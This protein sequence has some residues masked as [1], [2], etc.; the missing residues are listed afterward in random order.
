M[1]YL[2]I[3]NSA[4]GNAAAAAI[5]RFDLTGELVILGAESYPSYYRPLIPHLVDGTKHGDDLLREPSHMPPAVTVRLNCRVT[6]ID[7]AAGTVTLAG[8]EELGFD[9]LLLA[10]GS[11][12]IKPAIPGLG[13]PGVFTL[14]TWDDALA[15]RRAAGEGQRVVI[16]GGGRVGTKSAFA[17]RSLGLEVTV[18]ELM[19]RIV[20]Q[21]LD[22]VAA[23]IFAARIEQAGIRLRL[24]QTIREVI[25]EKGKLTGVV[26]NE[27]TRLPADIVLVCTGVRANVELAQAAG[28]VVGQGVHV[29]E[30]M[31]TSAPEVYAAGDVVET[32]D[33]VTGRTI[34][35]GI[36]TNAVGMG[37]CA[38]ENMAGGQRHFAAAFSLL[39]AMELGGLPV[40]SVGLIHPPE[41]EG[42]EVHAVRR[43]DTY[44][45]LVLQEGRLVGLILINEI[46]RAGVYQTL[47]RE[48]ADTTLF[49][50][51]LLS[52]RFHYGHFVSYQP[53]EVDRFL[54]V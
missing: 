41:G 14:R 38:G 43:G 31:R 18:V 23:S 49:R 13:Q 42:Y 21:Q 45:K 24:G 52:A 54:T 26:L 37:A 30:G 32:T 51:K 2:I 7:P 28:L 53:R 20:P 9:R 8:E 25:H 50:D 15:I 3:G 33:V 17:L 36:W 44:R 39:N 46:E 22:E 40:V 6:S 11:T 48:R 16:L 1:R 34:V 35:S 10:T 12:S 27:G 19:D 5:R 29:D 47:I 4:A